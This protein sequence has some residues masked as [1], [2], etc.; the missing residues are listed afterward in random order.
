VGLGFKDIKNFFGGQPKTLGKKDK[1]W[2]ELGN[3]I[4]PS[5]C[6][7][8]LIYSIGINLFR[9]VKKNDNI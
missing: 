1:F 8:K 4:V 6:M 9:I 5:K 3:W 2:F 7:A